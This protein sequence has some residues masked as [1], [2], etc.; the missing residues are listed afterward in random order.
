MD[1][2]AFEN[3]LIPNARLRELYLAMLRARRVEE[4][5]PPKQRAWTTG[6]EAC[7]IAPTI[8]LVR[9]DVI[10]D[11]LAGTTVRFLRG[12]SLESAINPQRKPRRAG[13]FAGAGVGTALPHPTDLPDRLW[14]AIGA[15][16]AVGTAVASTDSERPVAVVYLRS[17][18]GSPALRRKV[19]AFAAEHLVPAVFVVLPPRKRHA[20]GTTLAATKSGLPVMAVDHADAVAIYRVAQECI[21][22]ARAGGGPA[23]I[24]CVPFVL[25]GQNRAGE[26]GDPLANIERY[27]LER[28]IVTP[29][30][31]RRESRA[32]A[33]R[34][35]RPVH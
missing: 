15:A 6:L 27:I 14:A 30:W 33:S 35:P 31:I 24:E 2:P 17:D 9:P 22:R 13:L 29:E 10:S 34:I 7:L 8:G 12:S 23:L 25:K 1:E 32:L 16:L 18:Q 19:F 21:G 11:A 4:S 26:T 28:S 20:P 3:P 5:L